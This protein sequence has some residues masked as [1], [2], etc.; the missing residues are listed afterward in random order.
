M[1]H[2][3]P[4]LYVVGIG[5]SA[6]GLDAIQKLFDYL[7]ENTG[8]AFVIVQH[9]SP[10]F[11]SLMPELLAK[12]TRMPI[13]TAEDEQ[14]VLPNSIYLTQRNKNLHIRKNRLYLVEQGPK[15]N[16][17]LP[18]DI[19]F[20]TLGEEYREKSVGIILSGT[21]SDGSRGIKNIKEAGGTVIVQQ[22]ESAQFNGM[23]NSA[24][25]TTLADFIIPPHQIAETLLKIPN[26]RL[27]LHTDSESTTSDDVI[28]Y[29]ILDEVYKYSGIDFKQY[30][31]NTLLRRIEKRLQANNLEK[32]FD[33][34]TFLKSS[35]EE[36]DMLKQ[37]FLIGVT[38]FFRD[39]EAF[40]LLRKDILPGLLINR[41][42]KEVIRM[43]V[44]SCSTG[45]EAY[46]M[47]MLIDD[48]IS[49]HQLKCDYKIF[50]TDVDG[51]AL[52]TAS[53]GRYHISNAAEIDP[54]L[55][56]NYFIKTGDSIQIVKRLRDK[57]VFSNH[58]IIKDTPFIRMDLIS[59]RNMLIY[60][61]NM[62]QVRVL[63]N[64][65][66]SLKNDGILFLGTSESLG[67]MGKHFQVID[68]KWKFFRNVTGHKPTPFYE[69]PDQF[70][71]ATHY[72]N[73][74]ELLTRSELRVREK[75][76]SIFHRF[77]SQQY[78]PSCI[79]FDSEF[80][81][82]FIRGD[83]G[84]YLLLQE[85]IFQ[86]N[87][88]KMVEPDIATILQTGVRK[89][90]ESGKQV[91]IQ[92]VQ[93]SQQDPPSVFSLV[94]S[95]IVS[96]DEL[97][98][99]FMV[100]FDDFKSVEKSV[101]EFRDLAGDE[102]SLQRIS[103]LEGYL[104]E[105][106]SQLQ[107]VVEELETSNEELQSSNEELMA[108]NEELQST[109]E[110]LQSVNEELY[111]VNYELQ[112][113]NKEL[114]LLNND[115]NNL[116]NSTDVGTLFLDTEL[117]IRKFT[118]ALQ[119]HFSL[120]EED[121]GRPIANFA[122]NFNEQVRLAMLHDSRRSLRDLVTIEEEISDSNNKF[123][124]RRI[125]P[126]LTVDRKVDGLVIT[127]VDITELKKAFLE[128]EQKEEQIKKDAAYYKSILENNSFYLIK[129]DI[130]GNY[131][132]MN[133]YFCKM[134]G[135]KQED[136]MGKSSLGL[137]IPED[138][139][140][141]FQTVEKCFANPNQSAW[142]ILRKPSPKGVVTSQ[143]EF[144]L[145]LND[146]G[147]PVEVICI[148]HEITPLIRKQEELQAL[149]DVNT[150]Q[151]NRLMQYTHIVSHNIRSHVSNLKGIVE[152][153]DKKTATD[154]TEA[155][156]L[157]RNTV[158]SLDETIHNLNETIS[159][160]TNVNMPMKQI[161]LKDAMLVVE[162]SLNIQIQESKALLLKTYD[163]SATLWA[164]PAYFDSILLNLITNAIKYSSPERLPKI[165]I[166]CETSES[167]H[168]LTVTDNG[169]GIDLV[170]YKDK[171]FGM[172]KTF[173]RHKDAKGLGLFITKIQVEAMKGQIE[174][175]SKVG[176]GTTFKVL[177]PVAKAAVK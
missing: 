153:A 63:T 58:N 69:N 166:T 122:S 148:G 54:R 106:R 92:N 105:T 141:C 65:L 120:K 44:V 133:D 85:G 169:L 59:C 64:L 83:A 8:M 33:Y 46:S 1:N 17:N 131:T 124:I 75:S 173:H 176:V 136:W 132:Y 118:P 87:L 164:N 47:A 86:R 158:F 60:L 55:L 99:V 167:H 149:V 101:Y 150:E 127:F 77:L 76:D 53:Q 115:I 6:G 160:Q 78:S 4:E 112:E 121:V 42:P 107:N 16:L 50:A 9:L 172:Y 5:A 165:T 14:P 137:I 113:K 114:N 103:E 156:E 97:N 37:D 20:Q 45:E 18:I 70:N 142:V 119:Q 129:T 12:H 15:H 10:D 34:L 128:L 48:L 32:L 52:Q 56:E 161:R 168:I 90:D 49:S 134:F 130:Q 31:R 139:G 72:R 126:F 2:T 7:P 3:E 159:I 145:S 40:E 123:F 84:K 74:V 68:P 154:R 30:K 62:A 111:T 96:Q 117:R 26:S 94:F 82:L 79:F 102:V 157:I 98:G 51:N 170:R 108:S 140:L 23:P 21:G 38:Q 175:E 13:F 95:R 67:E 80:N 41:N 88:L 66:F 89:L 109:N 135:V 138:H 19:F 110:E 151:N 39:P 35:T 27:T 147:I 171:M 11:K 104:K 125:S 174:V 22:P 24:I 163:E 81:L 71:P 143:W 155:W 73:P 28:F 146:A 61:G 43:W 25:A 91:V 29:N 100:Y 36:R 116:L 144:K 57:I 162:N 152:L 177:L 93:A